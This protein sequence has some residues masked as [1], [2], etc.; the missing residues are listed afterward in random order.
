MKDDKSRSQVEFAF[1]SILFDL[2]AQCIRNKCE[3]GVHPVL[4]V[5]RHCVVSPSLTFSRVERSA[6]YWRDEIGS[7][8][9]NAAVSIEWVDSVVIGANLFDS[10]AM[11]LKLVYYTSF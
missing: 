6:C 5:P 3:L 1:V 9:N 2:R 8:K 4:I 11:L 10:T 7:R